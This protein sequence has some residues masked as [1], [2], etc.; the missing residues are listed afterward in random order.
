MPEKPD[1]RSVSAGSRS[2][3]EV[4]MIVRDE[5]RNLPWSLASVQGW[6]DRVWVVDSGSTDRTRDV[7][8]SWGAE[9][10]EREWP[11]YA[12]QKNWA[13]DHLPMTSDWILILDADESVLPDLRDELLAAARRPGGDG[14]DGFFINRYFV[15]LGRRIRHC[16]Y[17]PSWNLRFF[18]RGRARYEER[19]V[20]EHMRVEGPTGRLR[21]HLEH[22]DR[23]G[24]EAYAAKHN[25]YSTLEAREIVERERRGSAVDP[26]APPSGPHA[27]RRWV[28]D[29]LYASLPFKGTL[30]FLYMYVF[31]LGV[32]DGLAGL[33]FCAFIAGYETLIGLKIAESRREAA[34][35][36]SGRSTPLPPASP[37]DVR[38]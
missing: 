8:R 29:H 22:H 1:N 2:N 3:V 33:R 31:R 6:A 35:A 14:P 34:E 15:F 5:E 19:S 13:L 25:R 17:Y 20:H 10:V 12:R 37:H 24:L 16:G 28:K 21:G 26:H 7:A 4:L 36:R 23:R 30:R 11:G 38:A 32:L 27:W 9:V 18:R